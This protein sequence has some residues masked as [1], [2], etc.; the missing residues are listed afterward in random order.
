MDKVSVII[1]CHNNQ[2]YVGSAIDS[3]LNQTHQNL[4]IIVIDDASTDDSINIIKKYSFREGFTYLQNRKNLGAAA[5]RNRGIEYATGDYIAFLDADDEWFRDKLK[6]QIAI[7]QR[8]PE[9]PL[10]YS[11]ANVIDATGNIMQKRVSPTKITQKSL[12]FQN[13]IICSS[14]IY[15]VARCGGKQFFP[16][17]RKRQDFALWLNI[18]NNYGSAC[19]ANSVLVNYRITKNSV[20]RSNRLGLIYYNYRAMRLSTNLNIFQVLIYLFVQSVNS[21]IK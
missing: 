18:V 19:N 5:T 9:S 12:L 7:L 20:S 16:D 21:V 2:A 1:P 13:Q 8:Y 4:E 17:I 11:N 14:A 10:A 3:V 6:L 15:S